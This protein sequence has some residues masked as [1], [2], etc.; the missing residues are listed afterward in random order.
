MKTFN[1]VLIGFGSVGQGFAEILNE[2]AAALAARYQ[3][4]AT[5]VGV[6]TNRRGS[7]FRLDGLDIPMLLEAAEKGSLNHYPD[8]ARLIRGLNPVST[9]TRPGV[10]VVVEV[11]P[12]NWQGGEPAMGHVRAA[13]AAGKHVITAN[14][15]PI[16]FGYADF[17]AQAEHRDAFLGIEGTVMSGSPVIRLARSALAGCE[18]SEVRGIL[19][20]TTNFI[21][22]QM[23]SGKSYAEALAEAQRLGYAEA[24]PASDVEGHDTAGKLVILA[25]VL[26]GARMTPADVLRQGITQLTLPDIEA[27]RAAG[28]RW[29]L[30][31]QL[32]RD[33]GHQS[34]NG[35]SYWTASV[36]PMRLPLSDPLASVGGAM[37]AISY[38]TDLLGPLTL[39]GAG[40]GRRETGYAILSDLIELASRD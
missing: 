40:A 28:E 9:L 23:E 32:R 8:M 33:S 13:L 17:A 5:I 11:S 4:Q 38:Q 36:R 18:I 6:A 1:L 20:G 37:N 39:V 34:D 25:N 30:I 10:D 22:T 12:T 21:L 15:G 24:N 14:K 35:D 3:F 16:A 27:A 2:K 7:L 26:L 19:N 31:G 29:K